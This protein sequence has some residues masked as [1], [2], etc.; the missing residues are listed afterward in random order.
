MLIL[1]PGH[2]DPDDRK[3]YLNTNLAVQVIAPKL[4]ERRL[5]QAMAFI[6][7]I[8]KNNIDVEAKAKL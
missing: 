8:V 2:S 4:Q 3:V 6:D 5:L 1:C 7:N